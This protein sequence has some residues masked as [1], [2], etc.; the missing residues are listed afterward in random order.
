MTQVGLA[1]NRGTEVPADLS[2][3]DIG[4]LVVTGHC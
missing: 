3:R 2:G 4:N 1:S